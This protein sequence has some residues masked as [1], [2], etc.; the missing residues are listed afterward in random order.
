MSCSSRKLRLEGQVSAWA[1]YDGVAYRMLKRMQR[2]DK[3]PQDVDIL[4]LSA[5]YGLIR[6][7]TPIAF[8]DQRMTSAT[9]L[10]QA[11]RNRT[12]L[13]SV[14]ND[15]SYHTVFAAM[16]RVYMTAIEPT[17]EWL[18]ANVSF[19]VAEGGIGCKLR[20]LKIWLT[21]KD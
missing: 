10:E 14:L 13:R 9:A 5:R 16:G 12:I 3:F 17:S 4:I 15:S 21:A 20:H 2:E 8:Y 11:D 7:D 6:P 1:L 18:P 19:Q